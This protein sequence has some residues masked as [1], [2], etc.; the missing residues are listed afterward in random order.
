MTNLPAINITERL[1]HGSLLKC[2][3]GRWGTQDE[4]DMAGKQLI[5]LMT[6]RAIQRWQSEGAVETLVDTGAGLPDIDDLNGAIPQSEW[7][8]G[9]DGQPRPPW[10][11]QYAVYLL[12]TSDASLYTF[13]NGTTG[14][15]IAW[16][17]LVDR[18]SWMRALRGTQVFPLVK[19]DSKV[20]KTKFGAKL[21]PEFTIVNWRG[22][23]GSGGPPIGGGPQNALAEPVKTPTTAEELQDEVPF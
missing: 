12:D 22:F 5:A 16:E 3:D 6:A 21:R 2:I 17:R 14:A 9:L 19:L 15:K 11:P 1:I 4:A 13:A 7:E 23:G 10:Q 18:I 8:L 20:M